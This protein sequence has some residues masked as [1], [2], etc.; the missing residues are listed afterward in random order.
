[1]LWILYIWVFWNMG[2]YIRKTHCS[3]HCLKQKSV[4]PFDFYIFV[5]V[6]PASECHHSK[7][8]AKRNL[9]LTINVKHHLPHGGAHR[10][11]EAKPDFPSPTQW[12]VV[13]FRW[14]EKWTA[15][16]SVPNWRRWG[17]ENDECAKWLD[18]IQSM[19]SAWLHRPVKSPSY[20]GFWISQLLKGISNHWGG[21]DLHGETP[22]L[23]L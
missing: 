18:W 7:I 11:V 10:L 17:G 14:G 23:E 22:K 3:Y 4:K 12:V 13:S 19:S 15:H 21:D 6:R 20:G 16:W 1:M 5:A 9:V 2:C 8:N